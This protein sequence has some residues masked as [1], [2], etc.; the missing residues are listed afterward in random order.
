MNLLYFF[1]WWLTTSF[2]CVFVSSINIIT[3][4]R[5]LTR[6]YYLSSCLLLVVWRQ[7]D[8]IFNACWGSMGSWFIKR[9]NHSHPSLS[10]FLFANS[11]KLFSCRRCW[12]NRNDKALGGNSITSLQSSP[13]ILS[14][15]MCPTYH[16][17]LMMTADPDLGFVV[18]GSLIYLSTHFCITSNG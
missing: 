11:V 15:K 10:P 18:H 12:R 3:E 1:F 5:I 13:F 4:T 17:P 7:F 9:G 8:I 2:K 6:V 16:H 14:Q